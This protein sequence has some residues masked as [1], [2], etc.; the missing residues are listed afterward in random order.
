MNGS[1][2][3]A[4]YKLG[5]IP[6]FLAISSLLASL[7]QQ[8]EKLPLLNPPPSRLYADFLDYLDQFKPTAQIFI[9]YM[10]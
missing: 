2:D 8:S 4:T 1:S 5:L 7:P 10:R 3:F 9:I 6:L